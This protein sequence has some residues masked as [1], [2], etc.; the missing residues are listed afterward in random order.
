MKKAFGKTLAINF[1]GV[2][3][4]YTRLS[5]RSGTTFPLYKSAR[6]NKGPA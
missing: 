2:L 1:D 4:S 6:G 3:S 5:V